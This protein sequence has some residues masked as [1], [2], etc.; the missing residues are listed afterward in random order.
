VKTVVFKFWVALWIESHHYYG[1]H[2]KDH[3]T[4]ATEEEAEQFR[5]DQMG[6]GRTYQVLECSFEEKP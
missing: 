3:E 1:F 5:T 6:E 2:V 4:F